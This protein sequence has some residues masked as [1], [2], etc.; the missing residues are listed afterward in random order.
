[1][2]KKSIPSIGAEILR[3]RCAA[4]AQRAP[5][6]SHRGHGWN[7]VPSGPTRLH[8][9][10]EVKK[11]LAAQMLCAYYDR[12]C[13]SRTLFEGLGIAKD[14]TFARYLNK[15]PVLSVDVHEERAICV[16]KYARPRRL[17]AC[18][19]YAGEMA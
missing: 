18:G 16:R 10:G 17:S 8:G 14:E 15:F 4:G 12:S 1:M 13:D 3:L 19:R 2:Q 11:G 5:L 7:A 9:W 6:R